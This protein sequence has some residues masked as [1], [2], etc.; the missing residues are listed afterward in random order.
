MEEDLPGADLFVN[1]DARGVSATVGAGSGQ[2]ATGARPVP[3][4]L[5]PDDVYLADTYERA[6]NHVGE[7]YK[8]EGFLH[9]VVGPAE[10]L[11]RAATL[12]PSAALRPAP[13]TA[14]ARGRLRVRSVRASH[15]RRTARPGVQL[16]PGPGAR[17]GVR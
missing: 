7:L 6:I 15:T 11:G 10:I 17:R 13:A 4:D 2:V 3:I 5:S 12:D 8:N 1:P 16:P 14:D 9:A